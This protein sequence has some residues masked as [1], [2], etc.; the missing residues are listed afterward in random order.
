[1]PLV[2]HALHAMAI[3][4]RDLTAPMVYG[5]GLLVWFIANCFNN[6]IVGQWIQ[7]HLGPH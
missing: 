7:D 5:W 6:P 3:A 2:H 1:M 4:G